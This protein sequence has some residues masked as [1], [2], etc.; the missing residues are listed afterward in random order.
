MEYF[1]YRE[2]AEVNL[3]VNCDREPNTGGVVQVQL[4]RVSFVTQSYSFAN[5]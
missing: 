1:A 4:G 3:V 2:V 5:P